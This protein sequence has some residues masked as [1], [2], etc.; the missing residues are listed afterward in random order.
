MYYR[1]SYKP[2]KL[3][4]EAV[5]DFPPQYHLDDVPWI[6]TKES[7]CQSNSLQMIAAQK[8]IEKPT[9]YF[10]F[11]MGFTYGAFE[12]PAELG[13]FPF[14]DPETGFV[15]AAPYLGLVRRYYVTNDESLYLDALRYYLSR[16]YPVR[17]GLNVCTLRGEEGQLPHSEVLVGYDEMSFYYYETVMDEPRHLPPGE[18]GIRVHYQTLLEA[19]RGQAKVFSYPW[20]YSLTIFEEGPLREDLRPIW[21]RNGRSLIGGAEYTHWGAGAIEGLAKR[22][23]ERGVKLDVSK[24]RWGIDAAAY[25]RRDNA[26][27]LRED[28]AG[29]ADIERAADLFDEAAKLYAEALSALEKGIANQTEADQIAGMLSEAAALEREIGKIFL[30]QGA[31]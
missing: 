30:A 2:L 17:V 14:T 29:Q 26:T 16:G 25:T 5:G 19:V 4:A 31:K 27:Y 6:S 24:V 20:R 23:K 12:M 7:Y 11:L 18:K 13:F 10:N 22:I 9:G 21:A 15:V 28:F 3:S 8:G 1:I